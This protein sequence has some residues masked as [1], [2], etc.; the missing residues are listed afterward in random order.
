MDLYWIG[1]NWIAPDSIGVDW[2][3]ARLGLGALEVS[4]IELSIQ[5]SSMKFEGEANKEEEDEQE[6]DDE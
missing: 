1:F 5:L 4:E 2:I 6:E 3:D